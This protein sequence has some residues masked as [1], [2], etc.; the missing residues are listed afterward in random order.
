MNSPRRFPHATFVSTSPARRPAYFSST[1]THLAPARA[2]ASTPARLP[3]LLR[4]KVERLCHLLVS[5]YSLVPRRK[6]G[7]RSCHKKAQKAQNLS[8]VLG[9]YVSNSA[10]PEKKSSKTNQRQRRNM[11]AR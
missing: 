4:Q 10:K 2:T 3:R 6:T 11:K 7:R 9:S 8:G 5:L 1:Q